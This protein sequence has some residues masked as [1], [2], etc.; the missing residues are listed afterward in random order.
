M[1]VI[2][3]HLSWVSLALFLF[4]IWGLQFLTLTPDNRILMSPSDPRVEE[5]LEFETNFRAQNIVGIAISCPLRSTNCRPQLPETIR[6][7]HEAAYAIPY[8]V[9]VDSLSN[10]PALRSN[11]VSVERIDFIDTY[12]SDGCSSEQIAE[13]YLPI[14][15]RLVNQNGTT[16]AA[17]AALRFD[18]ADSAAVFDIQEAL[19]KIESNIELPKGASMHFVG[20]PP[21]MYA[22]VEASINEIFGF[23][24]LAILL[25]AILLVAAFGN[26]SLALTSLALSTATILT[27]LGLA[28]WSGLVL[29]TGSAAISTIILT[30][31]T[32]TAMHYFM[33]IV[34]VMSE[35]PFRDQAA[36]AYGAVSYQLTPILLTAATTFIAMLSMLLVES[37]PFRDLGLWTAISMPICCLYLFSVV[38]KVVE[39]LPKIK[40]SRWQLTLQPILNQHARAS[41]RRKSTAAVVGLLAVLAAA[42]ISQL[43]F[44]DDFVG[45]FS[46]ETRFR[47]DTEHVSNSLIGPTNL[48]VQV[49]SP[50]SIYD[51]G[52]LL[53]V[54]RLATTIRNIPSVENVYSIVDVLDFFTPHLTD[55]DWRSLDGDSVAQL[56]L[57]Y[58]LSL[59]DGQSKTDLISVDDSAVRLS[60]VARD[61]SSREIVGLDEELS[62]I[63]REMGLSAIVTGEAIPISYL[64][65]KNIPS[66]ATSLFLSI[67]GTSILLGFFFRNASLG[68]VLFF[69]TIVPIICGFGI[70]TLYADSIGIA[71]TIVLCICTGVVIDDTVHM[72]HRFSYAENTLKLGTNEA[73][74][75]AVHRVGN[76]ICTTTLIMVVGFGVLAFSSFKV[77][78]TFGICTVL[79]L[80]GALL[81]D[82]LILPTLLTF[83]SKRTEEK[84]EHQHESSNS[85]PADGL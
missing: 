6:Q 82:L 49:N 27:T 13:A 80:V 70:W 33:H 28:G 85:A 38:P 16:M 2:T 36:T 14:L 41:G 47:A 7:V 63:A 53:G 46:E 57:A 60:I 64:S 15:A 45:Y 78:S 10:Y 5:L 39:R 81:I 9:Q 51:P 77:N 4:A 58:E 65:E 79:I 1:R 73:V 83:S 52:F 71:A 56:V 21:L 20:R 48:E 76:A 74:S 31:T 42:N 18:T 72:I 34:R 40:P 12:C 84:I 66:I 26:V 55:Q 61:M 44:D 50:D 62:R 25:I 19:H 24:G 22:F 59:V 17:F 75:Y 30:L 3:R 8:V 67:L 68:A 35:D 54:D 37:P 23:M 43:H 29:S 11:D 69:T 32:A